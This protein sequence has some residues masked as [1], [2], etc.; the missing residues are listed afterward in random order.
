M[1]LGKIQPFFVGNCKLYKKFKITPPLLCTTYCWYHIFLFEN[2]IAISKVPVVS[3]HDFFEVLAVLEL[4]RRV[5]EPDERG[6]GHG[7][8]RQE[9]QVEQLGRPQQ[10]LPQRGKQHE[11]RAAGVAV[12]HSRAATVHET[13]RRRRPRLRA[14]MAGDAEGAATAGD[15]RSLNPPLRPRGGRRRPTSAPSSPSAAGTRA[16]AGR[17]PPCGAPARARRRRA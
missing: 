6:Y 13:A 14:A 9:R 8:H 12:G 4:E 3:Q 10:Q 2:S 17:P 16:R 11:P 1:Q 15:E 7:V 5:V